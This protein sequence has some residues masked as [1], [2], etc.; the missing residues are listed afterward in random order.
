MSLAVVHSRAVLGV[1]APAVTVEVHL[2]GG[3][4]SLSIVG[5][6][7]AAV[8]E[9]KDRVRSALI[10]AG[11][12][13]PQRRITVNLAPADLP[14]EGG[15]YDLAI[16]LGVL[17]ASRQ[18]PGGEL[19]GWEVLGELTLSGQVRP[20]S[21]VLPAAVA[22]RDVQRR[23]LVPRD[24]G[25]EAALVQDV[26]IRATAHLLEVCAALR[27][28]GELEKPVAAPDSGLEGLPDL[29][30]VKGQFQAR[31]AL[32]VAAAGG[33]NLLFSGPPGS[34]KSMLAARLPSLLPP[35]DERERLEVAAAYS[36]AGRSVGALARGERPFRNPHHTASAAALVGG[37]SQPRPGEISLAHRGVLFLDEL[38]EFPRAVLEVLRE[39]LETGEILISRAARQ[40]SFP[41]RFQLLAAM[42]PCPCGYFGDAGGRCRCT[43][44]QIQ[45]YQARLSGPLL[46]RF[47]MLLNVAALPADELLLPGGGGE[48]SA[49]VAQRVAAALD[50]QQRRQ[51]CPNREL[52]GTPLEQ[53]CGLDHAGRALLV[54][55]A[56][57]LGLSARACHRVLR[58]ARTLADLS[59]AQR[60]GEPQLLEAIGF[61]QGLADRG[62]R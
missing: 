51:G 12:D 32:E 50:I 30:D 58:V 59:G 24:N 2:S 8:R 15:R 57:R 35:L 4:P 62:N 10:N 45:R 20:V 36:V 6:P 53:A 60:V 16:A 43:P 9:S 13:Y 18:L 29:A 22:C 61:R 21:G 27:G 48:A 11:F 1:S 7:E 14:K 31:R 25:A 52:S 41:A 23:L 28:D 40:V 33:H 42:N 3:L 17:A 37:G 19:D 5:L 44:D 46:D 54:Q 56:S 55:A 26:D 49:S 39:P 47:D 38:P 34:G